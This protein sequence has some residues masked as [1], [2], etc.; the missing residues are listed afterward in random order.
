MFR[1][2]LERMVIFIPQKSV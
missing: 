1:E 2:Q